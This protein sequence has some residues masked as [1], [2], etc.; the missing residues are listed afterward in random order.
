MLL[1]IKRIYIRKELLNNL[2]K[3]KLRENK[4]KLSFYFNKNLLII[5]SNFYFNLYS[6][7]EELLDLSRVI[8]NLSSKK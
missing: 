6:K 8:T 4:T 2:K 5:N 7:E 3:N 1:I